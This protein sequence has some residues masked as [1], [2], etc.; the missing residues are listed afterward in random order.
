MDLPRPSMLK[1]DLTGMG[2]VYG[3]VL[4]L[5]AAALVIGLMSE[6]PVIP[7]VE[8]EPGVIGYPGSAE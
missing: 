8:D 2:I 4:A 6:R 7:A 3:L 1:R 5:L